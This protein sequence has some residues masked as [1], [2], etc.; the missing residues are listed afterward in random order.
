[1]KKTLFSC[2][3]SMTFFVASAQTNLYKESCTSIMVAK[4]AS[5][6]GS[7]MT[8]HTCDA[9]YR[10][11]V[12]MTPS[13]TYKAGDTEPVYW[14]VLHNEEPWD[15][16][17]VVEKGRIP[18]V[19][20][21]YAYLNTAYPCLNEKQLAIGETTIEGR[22]LLLNEN[23]LFLIEELER[24]ALQRC[25]NAVDAIKL[26]G[27]L[28]EQY[29]YADWGE[30]ITIADKKEVWQ[31]ELFGSG[32]GK[33]SAIWVAQ[34]IPDDHVGISANIPR[35]AKV[36]FNDP[37][38][39][40]YSSD[41]KER[42]KKLGLWDGKE[43]FVFWKI[44]N[45]KKPFSVREYFVL[46]ALAPSLNLKYEADELPFSVKPDKKVDVRDVLALYRQTYD[47]TRF[48]Q[49]ANLSVVVTRKDAIRGEYK[50][51][52]RP[53]STFMTNDMRALLNSLKPGVTERNRTIAVIQCS[54]SH[55]IQLRDWLPDEV[56]GV[57][58]FSFDN[59]AQSPK[60]PIYAGIT[61]LP[62]SY[63]VC[64]QKRYREDAAI[65]TFRETNRIATINWDKTRKIIE[66]Q[67]MGFENMHFRDA[68]QIENLAVQL[69]KEGKKEEARK[70]LTDYTNNF[71][72]SAMR[73][74]I[75]LKAELWTIFAR[76][77]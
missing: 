77:M 43:E 61:N 21:T 63:S 14:G 41:I 68:S 47:G 65:W 44:N 56:G 26:V 3:L 42:V 10:T 53:I 54:Y 11:W 18:A 73:R 30:C 24:I 32:P 6:D 39:F 4:G 46:N 7:V 51:T 75:E 22:E 12:E 23:G 15:M 36:D 31:M 2:L 16:R 33:P 29:G 40:L 62:K 25:D 76:S 57:A 13:K 59:P 69:I 17:N 9:N 50:D 1:M 70:L 20:S 74:W 8:A 52:V 28:A 55:V 66:P 19:A 72:A 60:I 27:K 48:D 64:G 67:V 37:R 5:T 58:Y 49:V 35:I 45:G 34:R 38:N 71:A